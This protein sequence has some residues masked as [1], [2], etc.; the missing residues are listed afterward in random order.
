M[1]LLFL[2]F[3]SLFK[4]LLHIAKPIHTYYIFTNEFADGCT[5]GIFTQECQK[6]EIQHKLWSA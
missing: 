6:N 1:R 2:L 3:N 5:A 4:N